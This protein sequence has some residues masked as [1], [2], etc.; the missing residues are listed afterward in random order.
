MFYRWKIRY[1]SIAS[2]ILLSLMLCNGAQAITVY[3]PVV[4]KGVLESEYQLDYNLDGNPTVNRSSTHR[5]ELSYG[6]TDRWKSAISAV[7]LDQNS[8][9][10]AYDR[11]KWENIY[12]LFEQAEY[13]LDAGLY[14]EYQLPDAKSNAP[15]V[16][17]G[18]LLLQKSPG[19]NGE[20]LPIRHTLNLVL[21]REMGAQGTHGA[22]FGY[23]WQ[24]VWNYSK[25]IRPGFEMYGD[26]GQFSN[27]N[28]PRQQSHLL[29]P[30]A[31]GELGHAFEY[32]LG[33]LIGLTKGSVNGLIKLV[34]EYKL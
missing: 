34:L 3:S 17:E 20:T 23:A 15:D 9:A 33:Y 29:G 18:K 8:R 11:L 19:A 27:L 1:S 22:A 13:W 4:E 32:Q 6:I 12:Q 2:A 31:S 25:E 21:K 7:Y 14:F 16:I 5:F 28:S 26:M 10:F 24:S 30:V